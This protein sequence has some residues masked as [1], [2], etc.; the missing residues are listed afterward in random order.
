MGSVQKITQIFTFLFNPFKTVKFF[1]DYYHFVENK[2]WAKYLLAYSEN[3]VLL[4]GAVHFI[5]LAF[6]SSN[7]HFENLVHFD[8]FNI[9]VS[10]AKMNILAGACSF[11]IMYYMELLFLWPDFALLKWLFKAMVQNDSSFF[12]WNKITSSK[13]DNR[14]VCE[15]LRKVFLKV[16]KSLLS[17]VVNLGEILN[18][19]YCIFT[20]DCSSRDP[21]CYCLPLCSL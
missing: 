5:Y 17:L 1:E 8:G 9:A 13:S 6:F 4:I 10:K 19:L 15:E 12:I 20:F 11:L 21:L 3:F 7:N 16:F 2:G 18:Y 14:D